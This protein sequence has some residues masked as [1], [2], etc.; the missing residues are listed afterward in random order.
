MNPVQNILAE[1]CR[2]NDAKEQAMAVMELLDDLRGFTKPVTLSP[3]ALLVQFSAVQRHY[4]KF[5]QRSIVVNYL[6]Y[7]TIIFKFPVQ[8]LN[9][10]N[11]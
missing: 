7:I 3:A 5:S 10:V 9:R 2:L 8:Y 11:C 6:S 1:S 4:H